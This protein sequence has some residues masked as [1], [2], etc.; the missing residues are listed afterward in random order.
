LETLKPDPTYKVGEFNPEADAFNVESSDGKKLLGKSLSNGNV[1]NGQ[2]VRSFF[3]ENGQV[4][5]DVK[6]KGR[7]IV[8]PRPEPKLPV[9]D[10]EFWPVTSAFLYSRIK[11]NQENFRDNFATNIT[12]WDASEIGYSGTT[13]V[14][15]FV[16]VP[17][18]MGDYLTGEDAVANN[19]KENRKLIPGG[20][21]DVGG[22]A[23]DAAWASGSPDAV[24][25]WFFIGNPS[26]MHAEA[27]TNKIIK[28]TGPPGHPLSVGSG[29]TNGGPGFCL[30]VTNFLGNSAC[31]FPSSERIGEKPLTKQLKT[32]FPNLG[33]TIGYWGTIWRWGGEIDYI[34]NVNYARHAPYPNETVQ[35]PTSY[36]QSYV[37]GGTLPWHKI[38]SDWFQFGWGTPPANPQKI[39]I[40][41]SSHVNVNTS[42]VD[43]LSECGGSIPAEAWYWGASSSPYLAIIDGYGDYW[44]GRD[45][46][47]YVCWRGHKDNIG[48]AQSFFEAFRQYWGIPGSV[49]KLASCNPYGCG[50]DAPGGGTTYPP[51][52]TGPARYL[53][54]TWGRKAGIFLRVCQK[55]S[56]LEIKIPI[57][58]AA[59]VEKYIAPSGIS[60]SSVGSSNIRN[61]MQTFA[62]GFPTSGFTRNCL[63][64]PH[65][66]LSI[67]GEFAYVNV[68][69]GCERIWG[70]P[71]SK[72]IPTTLDNLGAGL[73]SGRK[74]Y[75]E[76][77]VKET[78]GTGI[79]G[80]VVGEYVAP[81]T[82]ELLPRAE[83]DCFSYCLACKIKLPTET[84]RTL[85]IVETHVYRRG[86]S[87][88][89]TAKSPDTEFDNKYLI[90]DFRTN[91]TEN[92]PLPP[93]SPGGF[94]IAPWQVSNIEYASFGGLPALLQFPK[95]TFPVNLVIANMPRFYKPQE[96]WTDLDWIHYQLQEKPRLYNPTSEILPSGVKTSS[97][98]LLSPYNLVFDLDK[99][100]GRNGRAEM[101]SNPA[102]FSLSSDTSP[103]PSV[104]FNRAQN[105]EMLFISHKEQ[106]IG[107]G[108]I[109]N[110]RLTQWYRLSKASFPIDGQ[111]A[112]NNQ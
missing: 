52:P 8:I 91:R 50:T 73:F 31:V 30:M 89:L 78:L 42:A 26:S 16:Q 83:K 70:E 5:I 59:V 66:T 46:V 20:A 3:A 39:A 111:L 98:A 60:L 85:T 93:G 103:A 92:N 64:N 41:C 45:D 101:I 82:I 76:P 94:A 13:R 109:E 10:E 72:T 25:V 36:P 81:N 37:P 102:L 49:I 1:R 62:T 4:V 58:F 35:T 110:G 53:L 80:Y 19:L 48:M 2:K 68:S 24:T 97:H 84:D 29:R 12:S 32:S 33:G 38:N 44:D 74:F 61:T 90:H 21:G 28:V 87:I 15:L 17:T 6:P 56:H 43:A 100:F 7:D 96:N 75:R 63:E 104:T 95:L 77:G 40:T 54:E 108:L 79:V 18:D 88:T 55:D 9:K 22:A 23:D 99:R 69:F 112:R 57:E 65:G 47:N 107:N 105:A 86:E 106:L 14:N 34:G 67:D 71:R 27:T 11:P 51:A